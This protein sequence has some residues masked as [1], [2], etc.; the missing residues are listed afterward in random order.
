MIKKTVK[1][2]VG[3]SKRQSE[4]VMVRDRRKSGSFKY[5]SGVA[6]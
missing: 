6:G 2:T 3:L 1:E 4:P 5:H